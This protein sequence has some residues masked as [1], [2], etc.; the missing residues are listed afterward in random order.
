M[1]T[2]LETAFALCAAF[3]LALFGVGFVIGGVESA[4]KGEIVKTFGCVL[5][6]LWVTFLSLAAELYFRRASR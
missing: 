3:V 1:H 2:K 5:C 4:L 6:L